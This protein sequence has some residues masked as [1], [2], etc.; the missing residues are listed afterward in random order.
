MTKSAAD[1][2]AEMMVGLSVSDPELDTS[3]GS[4]VRKILDVVGG[5]IDSIGGHFMMA[6]TTLTATA[7]RTG[8]R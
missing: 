5:A 1:I 2:V 3:I 6:Y 4:T 8:A 7:R